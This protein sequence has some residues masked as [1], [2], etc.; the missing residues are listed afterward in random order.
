MYPINGVL[1][2]CNLAQLL[3]LVLV[4][5]PTIVAAE[6]SIPDEKLLKHGD[7]IWPRSPN[8][9]ILYRL[10]P[11]GDNS[12]DRKTWEKDKKAYIANTKNSGSST[13]EKAAAEWLQEIS[14]DQFRYS[15]FG[16]AQD[17]H[18]EMFGLPAPYTGHVGIIS[19]E[20]GKAWV[21]EAVQGGV[22]II[23]YKD[24]LAER[25]SADVWVGRLKKIKSSDLKRIVK[26]AKK[27]I[28]KP[29][30]LMNRDLADDSSFYCSKLVWFSV[31][32][33][34]K[35]A[36]DNDP[37]PRRFGWYSPKQLMGSPYIQLMFS[38]G[39]YLY[40]N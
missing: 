15:Y 11:T 2:S 34:L 30:R 8:Q 25:K 31:F 37:D 33:S 32:N 29:Y 4:C 21:V 10:E 40:K 27:Q 14:Y 16:T 28:G 13:Y 22:Q 39:P 12:V 1:K 17:E 20:K 24:W 36:L 6:R 7:L 35:I 3:L 38:S 18:Q 9:F 23:P 5:L 26:V 19:I